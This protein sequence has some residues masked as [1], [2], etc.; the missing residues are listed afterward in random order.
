MDS[1]LDISQWALAKALGVSQG[2]LSQWLRDLPP[3]PAG[4]EARI[5]AALDQ[6]EEEQRVAAEAIEKLR[7]E[8]AAQEARER[9]LA[10]EAE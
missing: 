2:A 3:L 8:R 7:A 1:G 9:A 5:D 6:I 10:E 4:M